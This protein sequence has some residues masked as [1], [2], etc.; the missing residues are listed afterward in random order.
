[1]KKFLGAVGGF[2]KR[3][4]YIFW[5]LTIAA[6]VYG[7]ALINSVSR[8][9]D[10]EKGFLATQILAVGLGYICAVV[11]SLMDYNVV[12]KFWYIFAAV[13]VLALVYTSI[14]GIQVAGTD[15]KAWI[16]IAGRT[17]QTSELVKIFFIVTFAKHLAVLKERNKLKTFLGVMTLCLHA[18]VPIGLI[19]FM[20]DDGTA[21]VFGFMFLIMTFVAG[22]QLRYYLALIICAGFCVPI[23]WYKVLHE[24]QRTRFLTLFNLESDPNGFGYQQLQGKISIASGEMYGRGYYEGPR[25]AAGSVPY[26]E[27]DFIFSVAGEELGFIGCVVLLGLLLLLILRCVMN[28]LSAKDDLGK[29][30]CFGFFAMLAVQTVINVGMCLGLLPVIGITLPFFSSGGSSVACLYLGVGIVESV[31]MHRHNIEKEIDFSHLHAA[32]AGAQQ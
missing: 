29:F 4:D 8:S 12:C 31:Y 21:L 3:T 14:F 15:D 28:A 26:Q 22:V 10:S 2:F 25:V 23:I 30:L 1:M 27:N 24:E 9:A 18:L 16:R 13:G 32:Q 17:F 6:S 5:I 7:F 11:I 20:G 19:H